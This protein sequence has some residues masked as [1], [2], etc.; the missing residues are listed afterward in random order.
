[1]F[2]LLIV[3][4]SLLFGS[5][6]LAYKF[7]SCV[8]LDCGYFVLDVVLECTFDVDFIAYSE[9]VYTFTLESEALD[10][11]FFQSGNNDCYGDVLIL[12]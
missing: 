5:N 1:M 3:Y 9:S 2:L 11:I 10:R 6:Y 12:F 4:E 7:A 8:K